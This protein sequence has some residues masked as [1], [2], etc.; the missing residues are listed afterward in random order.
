MSALQ[1]TSYCQLR[2]LEGLQVQIS[3][4]G[5]Q[6]VVKK[7][8]LNHGTMSTDWKK[9]NPNQSILTRTSSP[10]RQRDSW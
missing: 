6:I 3:V 7:W 1:T 4:S 5:V 10:T 9:F 8:T 2:G